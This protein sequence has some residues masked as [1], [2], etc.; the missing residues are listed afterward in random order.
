M[1]YIKFEELVPGGIY[2]LD[3]DQGWLFR[4]KEIRNKS[5]HT[6]SSMTFKE[7]EMRGQLP[8]L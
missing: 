6:L 2:F 7:R 4:V 1:K 5:I 8:N 3:Y